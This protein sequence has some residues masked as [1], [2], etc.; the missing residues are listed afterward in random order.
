MSLNE[1]IKNEII[2]QMNEGVQIDTVAHAIQ[3]EQ[4]DEQLV[5][6]Q[7]KKLKHSKGKT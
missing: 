3:E 1:K 7:E 6:Q 5:M 2:Q 4:V